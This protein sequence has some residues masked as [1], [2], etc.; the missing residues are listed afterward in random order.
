MKFLWIIPVLLIS[1]PVVWFNVQTHYRKGREFD[2]AFKVK[3]QN[4][5]Q[6]FKE[7]DNDTNRSILGTAKKGNTSTAKAKTVD[8]FDQQMQSFD[9][10]FSEAWNKF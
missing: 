5:M 6:E 4:V 3:V 2:N 9:K 10:S 7:H 1:I 8:T